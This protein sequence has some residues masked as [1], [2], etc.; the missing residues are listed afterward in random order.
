MLQWCDTTQTTHDV[1]MTLAATLHVGAD[2][3][4]IP[5]AYNLALAL[6]SAQ[7]KPRRAV[8]A[9]DRTTF[10]DEFSSSVQRSVPAGSG[11][12]PSM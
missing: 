6:H 10:T 3:A 8:C 1:C 5:N 7:A 12:A 4:N 2:A 11:Q 9:E